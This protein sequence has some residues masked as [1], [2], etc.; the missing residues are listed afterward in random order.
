LTGD[1]NLL[2]TVDILCLV[3]GFY[4]LLFQGQLSKL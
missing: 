2:H 4:R 3:G 1:R